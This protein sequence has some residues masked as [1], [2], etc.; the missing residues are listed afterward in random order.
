MGGV[1]ATASVRAG[2]AKAEATPEVAADDMVAVLD[3]AG[4]SMRHAVD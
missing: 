3:A 1:M 4:E 2:K